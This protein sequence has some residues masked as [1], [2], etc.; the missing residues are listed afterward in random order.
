MHRKILFL[1]SSKDKGSLIEKIYSELSFILNGSVI[2]EVIENICDGDVNSINSSYDAV[3]L[4]PCYDCRWLDHVCIPIL[5]QSETPLNSIEYLS[6]K[7]IYVT[8]LSF[9]SFYDRACS[10][11]LALSS[12]MSRPIPWAEKNYDVVYLGRYT[13]S[14]NEGPLWFKWILNRYVDRFVD[15]I[16]SSDELENNPIFLRVKS[17]FFKAGLKAKYYK[18]L[19]FFNHM[20]RNRR[21]DI[22]VDDAI[23]AAKSGIKVCFITNKL[24]ASR[25]PQINGIEV[26]E[27][28]ELTKLEQLVA[29][30]KFCVVQTP[31]HFSTL[32]ERFVSAISAG[33][34]PVYDDY[35][36][37]LPLAHNV[38]VSLVY[39]YSNRLPSV[40]IKEIINDPCFENFDFIS[41][42][43]KNLQQYSDPDVIRDKY[44][45]FLTSFN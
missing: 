13:K 2:L 14:K 25:L 23:R 4:R 15:K 39:N 11:P 45:K 44:F 21:R 5:F 43:Q 40:L 3:F 1:I 42:L 29:K 33:T 32:N 17:L 18:Y 31:F 41:I 8:D 6:E 9:V 35:P 10:L 36:Q 12:R 22:L 34:I 28:I 16:I 27:D 20:V 24:G 30:S 37:Y 19:W 26:F 7:F 38:D